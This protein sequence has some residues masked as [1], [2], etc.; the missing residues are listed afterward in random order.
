MTALY[1]HVH[2][3]AAIAAQ[4]HRRGVDVLTAQD[5]DAT[6][7]E[8]AALLVRATALGR[9]LFTQDIRFKSLA[10]SW[11]RTGRNFAG[12]LFGTSWAA[13]SVSTCAISS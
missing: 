10:E 13:R 9:V 8:D 5:D 7:L 12:L 3:P 1:L 11:Q 6:E 2:V 4:L